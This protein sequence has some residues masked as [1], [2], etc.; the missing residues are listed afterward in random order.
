M[1]VQDD[2]TPFIAQPIS[3]AIFGVTLCIVIITIIRQF[4]KPTLA[5]QYILH[6]RLRILL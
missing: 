6:K 1:R 3:G 4:K 2:F 5:Y